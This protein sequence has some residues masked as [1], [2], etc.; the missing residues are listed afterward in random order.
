[1]CSI[2]EEKGMEVG[3]RRKENGCVGEKKG[4]IIEFLRFGSYPAFCWL[5]NTKRPSLHLP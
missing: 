5:M 2:Q 1:V 3:A 4:Y